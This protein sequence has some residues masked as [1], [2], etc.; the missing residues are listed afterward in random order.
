MP[1]GA[2]GHEAARAEPVDRR[3]PDPEH[4][5][6][7]P[8]ARAQYSGRSRPFETVLSAPSRAGPAFSKPCWLFLDFVV[9]RLLPRRRT[10]K[11]RNRFRGASASPSA[12]WAWQSVKI[13]G[14]MRTAVAGGWTTECR[15]CPVALSFPEGPIHGEQ[16]RA[17]EAIGKP[18][19]PEIPEFSRTALPECR[20]TAVSGAHSSRLRG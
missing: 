2:P 19:K 11:C 6:E 14:A 5:R 20:S 1:P 12:P 4:R 17:T 15:M 10:T 3:K 8:A 9:R 13:P 7:A 18:A 16:A